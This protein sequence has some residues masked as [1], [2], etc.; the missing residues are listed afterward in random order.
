MGCN[1][2]KTQK[3][4]GKLADGVEE[5]NNT[6]E[7]GLLERLVNIVMQFIFGLI[8]GAIL[9]V[10]IGPM[11]VYII[12]CLVLGKEPSFRIINFRKRFNKND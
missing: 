12:G 6:E 3:T 11:L 1:C 10:C 4:F 9:L 8:V 5:Q 7:I 2:K